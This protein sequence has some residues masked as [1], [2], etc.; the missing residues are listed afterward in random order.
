GA[1]HPREQ[2]AAD[3]TQLKAEIL[4]R[5]GVTAAARAQRYHDWRYRGDR[6]PRTQLFDLIHLARKWLRPEAHSS[7]KMMEFL[8]VDR[9]TRGLPPDLRTWVGQND[10]ATYDEVVSLV[11]RQLRLGCPPTIPHV[12]NTGGPPGIHWV[13]PF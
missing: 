1:Q 6:A 12:H 4:A 10:P 9:Y 3:Y 2:S 8:V 11:E 13:L 7:E 5:A